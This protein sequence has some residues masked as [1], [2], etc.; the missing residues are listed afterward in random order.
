M[1]Q[2]QGLDAS[3]LQVMGVKPAA[4]AHEPFTPPVEVEPTQIQLGPAHGARLK[5]LLAEIDP[6]YTI[7]PQVEEL[8]LLMV[9]DFV[10]SLV[11]H[12]LKL[13]KHR[14][15]GVL[16]TKDLKMC[17]EKQRG[18]PWLGVGAPPG[19]LAKSRATRGSQ[20]PPAQAIQLGHINGSGA[21]GQVRTSCIPI[22]RPP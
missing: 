19:P 12:S 2:A 14:N 1:Q 5:A 16:E 21:Q 9:H 15:S 22:D 4:Q 10:Q 17:L 3:G 20:P 6:S 18:M 8:L 7:S 13:A 11:T